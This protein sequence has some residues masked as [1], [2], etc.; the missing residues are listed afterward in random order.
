MFLPARRERFNK[1]KKAKNQKKINVKVILFIVFLLITIFVLLFGFSHFRKE[2]KITIVSR[3]KSGDVLVIN[4]DRSASKITTVRIPGDTE[5]EVARQLGAWRLKSVWQLGLN[6]KIGGRLLATTIIKN[7]HFPVF[8][9]TDSLGAGLAS[10]SASSILKAVVIPY[11]TNLGFGDKVRLALFSLGVKNIDRQEINLG[12]SS[13]LRETNLKDGERGYEIFGQ[14]PE[15]LLPV[16][17]DPYLAQKEA[18]IVII[19]TSGEARLSSMLGAIL[20]TLG[21]QVVAI[22]ERNETDINCEISGNDSLIEYKIN[23]LLDCRKS[24]VEPEGNYDFQII[25][26]KEFAERF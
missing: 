17:Y 22:F 1:Y 4:F 9:W 5:V 16:F 23:L 2:S 25:I 12:K 21:G 6:E 24:K 19:N 18:K 8:A 20:R 26:G 14:I 7:F 13:Y 3:E 11:D 10:D 15:K